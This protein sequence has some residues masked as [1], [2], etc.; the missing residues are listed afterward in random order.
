MPV[1]FKAMLT[2]TE[3][4]GKVQQSCSHH[5]EMKSCPRC[6]FLSGMTPWTWA[7]DLNPHGLTLELDLIPRLSLL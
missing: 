3:M 6:L 7:H 1:D 2:I 5:I 4:M